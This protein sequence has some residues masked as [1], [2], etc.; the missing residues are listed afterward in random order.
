MLIISVDYDV[1]KE[2][3]IILGRSFFFFP[4]GKALVDVHRRELTMRVQDQEITFYV[5]DSMRYPADT[6]ECLVV[7]LANDLFVDNL[8]LELLLEYI[9]NGGTMTQEDASMGNKKIV[10]SR[11][12]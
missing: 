10:L 6:K 1:D 7:H 5:F 11:E 9:Q 12:C 4:K 3:L 2:V 8:S